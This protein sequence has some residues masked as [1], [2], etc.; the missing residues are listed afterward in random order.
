MAV[1]ED[2]LLENPRFADPNDPVHKEIRAM[3]FRSNVRQALALEVSS[4]K[5][6]WS[7]PTEEEVGRAAAEMVGVI[8]PAFIGKLEPEA[9]P[10]PPAAPR[11]PTAK[12][13]IAMLRGAVTKED[14]QDLLPEGESRKTVLEAYEKMLEALTPTAADPEPQGSWRVRGSGKT[15][16]QVVWHADD[17]WS[18]TCPFFTEK[19]KE[20]KHIHGIAERLQGASQEA[21]ADPD[22]APRIRP[23]APSG[24]RSRR[25]TAVPGE[26]ILIGGSPPPPQSDPWAAPTETEGRRVEVGGTVTMGGTPPKKRGG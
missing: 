14:L 8:P 18:C 10:K 3:D 4:R 13:V 25:N 26:G 12:Q 7:I 24:F 19:K 2:L 17:A 5:G 16:Y 6:D 21:P 9:A 11:P 15:D 22:P 23:G 1:Q 20:C